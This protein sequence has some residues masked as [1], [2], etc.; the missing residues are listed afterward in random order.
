MYTDRGSR[1]KHSRMDDEKIYKRRK[2]NTKEIE[3]HEVLREEG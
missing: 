1:G 2:E 3:A